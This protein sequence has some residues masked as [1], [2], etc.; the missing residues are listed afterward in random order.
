[1][2]FLVTYDFARMLE[3]LNG[4]AP[5]EYICE[6]WTSEPDLSFLDQIHQMPRLNT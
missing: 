4:V 1:M 2:G 5:Y 3:T 6:I